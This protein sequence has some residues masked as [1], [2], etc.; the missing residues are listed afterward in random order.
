MPWALD[1]NVWIMGIAQTVTLMG[2]TSRQLHQKELRKLNDIGAEAQQEFRAAWERVAEARRREIATAL[3]SLAED[4]VE[5]DFRDVF[6]VMLDDPE[7]AVRIAAV[8]GLWEDD[9]VSTLRRLLPMLADDLDDD[10]RSSVALALGR[11]AYRASIDELPA[12][13]S[14][15]VRQALLQNALNLDEADDVRRR[16]IE[17]LGYYGGDEIAGVIGQ[18]YASG[19]QSLKESALVAM[20]HTLDTRWL[21]ILDAELQS[22]EPSVRYEAARAAGELS[23]DAV[24]LLPRLVPLTEGDDSEVA[25]AA[26]WA[27]GQIGGEGARRILKRLSQ[28]DDPSRQQAAD[29]ALSDLQLDQGSFG[30]L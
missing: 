14:K 13:V 20:G 12:R 4:N 3:A 6:S 28:S 18:A 24:S 17:G 1:F 23:S 19:K 16:A 8:D 9:R 5:F 29:E 26:I 27:L 25:Q 2:D 7:A 21:P 11:F 22:S 30:L 10:V 15:D